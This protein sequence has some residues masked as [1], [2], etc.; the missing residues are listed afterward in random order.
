MTSPAATRPVVDAHHHLWRYSPEEYPW[1]G[2][3]MHILRRD[4][5]VRDLAQVTEAAGVTHTVVV[6]ARQSLQETRDLLAAAHASER[7]AGVVGWLP[8]TAPAALDHALEALAPEALLRGARHV[9]QDEAA[10]FLDRADVND[11]LKTLIRHG[12][13]YDLLLQAGQLS[14]ATRCVD[15]NPSGTFVLDHAAKPRIATG[16]LDEWS[17]DLH[18]LS[19]RSNVVCKLSGLVTEAVW[20][21]WSL[22]TLRPWLDATVDAFGPDRLLAGSDWPV[23]LVAVSYQRWWQTLAAYFAPFSSS[24]RAAIFGGNATRVYR[25]AVS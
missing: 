6:Q 11:G 25:L 21:R 16:E 10:G 9:V 23:C 17:R 12:L 1:I 15:R 22:D 8:L 19:R 24:E 3:R 5:T 2:E 14:E 7:I 13:S 20:D 4:F 18:A